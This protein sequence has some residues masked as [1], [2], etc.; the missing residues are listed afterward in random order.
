MPSPHVCDA[1]ACHIC[2]RNRLTVHSRGLLS[3]FWDTDL[4]VG[5]GAAGYTN[6]AHLTMDAAFP[7]V[8]AETCGA[9]T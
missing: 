5:D 2:Q 7:V 4:A 6:N 3:L 8:R 9:S 1:T